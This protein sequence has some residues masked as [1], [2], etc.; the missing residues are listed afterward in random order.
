MSQFMIFLT[1][2]RFLLV[3]LAFTFILFSRSLTHNFVWDDHTFIQNRSQFTPLTLS[4]ILNGKYPVPTTSRY[5][6]I[7][8]LLDLPT[9][10]IFQQNPHFYHLFTLSLHLIVIIQIYHLTFS[11]TQ[12][13]LT[14]S[15]TTTLFALHPIHVEAI[16]WITAGLDLIFVIFYLAA[17]QL[18]LHTRR[19]QNPLTYRFTLLFTF[20]ALFSNELASTL[21]FTLLLLD[22]F[23]LRT[24]LQHKSNQHIH[25]VTFILLFFY[26]FIRQAILNFSTTDPPVYPSFIF[27]LFLSLNLLGYHFKQLIFPHL[28][29]VDHPLTPGL[30]GLYTLNFPSNSTPPPLSLSLPFVQISLLSILIFALLLFRSYRKHH[31][32]TFCLLWI[33]LSL[34]PVLQLIPLPIIYSERQTYLASIPF[35]LVLGMILSS[36]LQKRASRIATITFISAYTLFFITQIHTYLPQW[37]ND[38]TLWTHALTHQPNSAIAHNSL[39][40]YYYLHQDYPSA[41]THYQQSITLNPYPQT[42]QQNAINIFTKLELHQQLINFYHFF[43]D[44]DPH[45][46]ELLFRIGQI[47]HTKIHDYS[48]AYSFY[49]QALEASPSNY[50]LQQARD[51]L[52]PFLPSP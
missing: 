2:H 51:Q 31:L 40:T 38:Y 50:R 14:T 23:H 46:P 18:F 25:Q 43:L 28:L 21:P 37:H 3:L 27:Q 45:N 26:W 5:R 41:L 15:I 12:N 16:T 29:T 9:H 49:S 47:Y 8:N 48:T 42:Y 22:H 34:L 4:N 19:T 10:L 30:S 32:L 1:R 7:R 52:L 20:L 17:I 39:G 36:L 24:P 13:R 44:Q 11:L 6:P 33:P 35:C